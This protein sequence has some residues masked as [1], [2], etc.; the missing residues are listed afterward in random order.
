VFHDTFFALLKEAVKCSLTLV[1]IEEGPAKALVP[2]A[3]AIKARMNNFF[4]VF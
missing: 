3:M 2:V 4:I 1:L